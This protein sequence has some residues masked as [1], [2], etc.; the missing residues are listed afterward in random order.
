MSPVA[1]RARK[2]SPSKAQ[3]QTQD[4]RTQYLFIAELAGEA[5]RYEGA[6]RV[7]LPS[8]APEPIIVLVDVTTQIKLIVQH[9]G[10]QLTLDERNLL[11]VAYKNI[12]N[13]LRNSWRIVD[14]LEKM[15][16]TRKGGKAPLIRMQRGRI[17]AELERVC[18]DIVGL[19]EGKLVRG[20]KAGEE[21]VFY[22]KM[23]GD[24]YRYLAEFAGQKE[25]R[26]KYAE[27][28][29]TAYKLAYMHALSV[30]EP[31]HPTRLGLALNFSVFYHDVKQ[32]PERAC[33]LAKSALDDAVSSFSEDT[34]MSTT[35]RDSLMILQLL[36]DDL[37]LWSAE[38]M[39]AP[40]P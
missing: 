15:E 30:L 16:A 39:N 31:T 10:P 7:S 25:A 12:T 9:F 23:K 33:H 38:M 22:L 35:M 5:E 6:L 13:N 14:T 2:Q 1:V 17:E 26:N 19:L 28:S 37:V 18:R 32:S 11:S 4:K 36:R 21:R 29:L 24:Y 27:E 3:A 40:G 8:G 20:A 34:T